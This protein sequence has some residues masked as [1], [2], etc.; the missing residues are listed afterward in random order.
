MG[1]HTGSAFPFRVGITGVLGSKSDEEVISTSIRN[2]IL[3]PQGRQP[4]DP[5]IG[6]LIPSLVFEPNDIITTQLIRYYTKK[7]LEEQEPRI[8]VSGVL[9][10]SVGEH[11]ITIRVGYIIRGDPQHR[12]RA[13]PVEVTRELV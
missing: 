13:I 1:R 5:T 7:A 2:I 3:T 6:S 4:Y 8:D 9:V 12:Q 10:Q 11:T